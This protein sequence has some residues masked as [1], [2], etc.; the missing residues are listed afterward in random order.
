MASHVSGCRARRP[1]SAGPHLGQG[2]ARDRASGAAQP[3]DTLRFLGLSR[4]HPSTIS[5]SCSGSVVTGGQ[6]VFLR[7]STIFACCMPSNKPRRYATQAGYGRLFAFSW[8]I[9]FSVRIVV[10]GWIVDGGGDCFGSAW[11]GVEKMATHNRYGT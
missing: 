1:R 10:P 5:R 7:P 6:K 9:L 11:D 4:T 2:N 3:T 8:H